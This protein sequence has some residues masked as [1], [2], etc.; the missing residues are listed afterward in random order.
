MYNRIYNPYTKRFVKTNS[1]KGKNILNNYLSMLGV[2]L[3]LMNR[4]NK[5]LF[6]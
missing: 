5:H 1:V 4:P 3:N 2:H 6:I